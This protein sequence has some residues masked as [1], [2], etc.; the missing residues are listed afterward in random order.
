MTFILERH[1]NGADRVIELKLEE[2]ELTRFK[3]SSHIILEHQQ[4]ADALIESILNK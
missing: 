4:R 3:Q 2:D 1:G